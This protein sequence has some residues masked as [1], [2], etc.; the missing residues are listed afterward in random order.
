MRRGTTIA[1]IIGLAA[2]A[3][4]VVYAGIGAVGRAVATLHIG[5]LAV[6]VLLHVPM[7]VLM[8]I[9]WWL[10]AGDDPPASQMRFVWA[11]FVRD[12]AGE[13][14]PTLQFGGVVFGL[15]A[16]GRGGVITLG[17]V[18]A[19]IDGIVELAAKVPYVLAALLILVAFAPGQR[20]VH[21]LL[22]ALCITALAVAL[23][24]FARRRLGASLQ[25]IARAIS[26]RWPSVLPLRDLSGRDVQAS[27]ERI[28][29]Q[30]GRLWSAFAAH[31]CC[32]CLGAVEVWVTF[33]L[34]GVDLTAWQALAIDGTVAALRTFALMVPAAAGVQEASYLLAA[35][36]FGIPPAAAIAAS[37]ARRARDLV[38]GTAVLGIAA[39]SDANSALLTHPR[40]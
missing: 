9:A 16:L 4:A 30:R 37:F 23:L 8:G 39:T 35:A 12:A 6:L 17:A 26:T 34:L 7:V 20:L 10:A 33:H 29:R 13:L 18:S 22:L 27:F 31:L 25:A 21:L 28:L 38:L 11:R 1:L 19:S 15:R 5:G 2:M 40:R 24:V 3:G 32:W 36:V 14:L